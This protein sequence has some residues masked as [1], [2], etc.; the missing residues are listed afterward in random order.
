MRRRRTTW[1]ATAVATVLAVMGL[2]APAAATNSTGGMVRLAGEGAPALPS[3][4]TSAG[5]LPASTPLTVDVTLKVRAPGTLSAFLAGLA[6]RSSPDFHHYLRPAAFGARFGAS[7]SAV[8]AVEDFLRRA[9]L[10][11]VRLSPDRLDIQAHG[12]AGDIARAFRVT[13]ESYRLPTGRVFANTAA[14]ALPA[15]L[16]PAVQAVIGLDDISRSH[17]LLQ[18]AVAPSTERHAAPA[19][20]SAAGP[21][22]CSAASTAATDSGSYTANQLASHY[23]MT[24]LYGLGDLGQGVRVGLA[25]FEPNLHS[26]ITA[27]AS[28]YGLSTTVNY[29]PVD[30]GSGSGAGQGEAA[31]DIEDVMGL[32]PDATIDVYQGPA[33]ASNTATYDVFKA[34]INGDADQV[35]STSWGQCEQGEDA[36]FA[37]SEQALFQEAAAQGQTVLAAAGDDG[38]TDCYGELGGSQASALAVDDPGSQPYVVSV[39]GTSIGSGA[40]TVW[41]D[42]SSA[43]G[44]GGGGV[45]VRWCMPTY[46]DQTA[47]PGI[48]NTGSTTCGSGSGPAREVPD[49]AANADPLTGYVVYFQGSWSGGVGGTSAAAPLWAAAA[50]LI[51]ASP[52]CRAWSS[53]TPGVMATSLYATVAAN[54]G[55]IYGSPPSYQALYDVTSGTNDYTPSAYSGGLYRAGPGFDEASG[56]GTPVLG[57]LTP[58][59]QPSSFYP[60]LAALMCWSAATA[61]PD[62]SVTAVTPAQGASVG[63]TTVTLTGTGFLPVAGADEVL[64]GS[65]TVPA[66]CPTTTTCTAALPAGT[67]GTVDLRVVVE[68]LAESPATAADRFTFGAPPRVTITSP[69]LAEDVSPTTTVRYGATVA[70]G[71]VA[72]YD[73]RYRSAAWNS[74]YFS[75]YQYPAAWQA[76]AATAETLAAAPGTEYCFGVRARSAAGVTSAWAPDRCTIVPLGASAL[77]PIGPGWTTRATT[78]YYLGR[79]LTTTRTGAQLQLPEAIAS[80]IALVVQGC[81]RCGTVS[82]WMGGLRLG[83][84]STARKATIGRLVINLAPFNLRRADV[85]ITVTSSG[86]PV[87]IEGI[88]V[89]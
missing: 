71:L 30:G 5:P 89:G 1:K 82:I 80:R 6:N 22:P 68:N 72:S 50:A 64:A 7:P 25:E 26:D 66:S 14:P 12:P 69:T 29:L 77:R 8:V 32:A 61:R 53:G 21:K 34:M 65:T 59:R 87:T 49:V 2:A 37:Q 40:E 81:A 44:A 73:V 39:G 11:S 41:N 54:A 4:A 83:T 46:Q 58:S 10:T 38:S 45:S 13:L 27:Y 28:C 55:L 74:R 62:V 24:T 79:A 16:A 88:A 36:A 67:A 35:I 86:A 76:T 3:A 85:T 60:G 47:I 20:A 84:A 43:N 42:S 19:S 48:Q 9:G 23:G 15:S 56:L 17:S 33:S 75:P 78:A 18:R 31:L 52:F 51:D 57:G 70:G 63:T